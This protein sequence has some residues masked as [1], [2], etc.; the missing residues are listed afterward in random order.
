MVYVTMVDSMEIKRILDIRQILKNK[1]CFLFG[2][3]Q[4]GKTSLIA[5][6]FPQIKTIDLLL[7]ENFR[8]YSAHPERLRQ[9]ITGEDK[10][11]IIDEIQRLPELLNEVHY[12]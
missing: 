6:Q 4:T 7:S 8:K 2:P 10:I 1:S 9:E 12:L 5:Q 3:R 11:V